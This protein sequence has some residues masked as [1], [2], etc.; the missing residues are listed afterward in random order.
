MKGTTR[1]WS[2]ILAISFVLIGAINW[3]VIGLGYSNV[4]TRLVS[5]NSA[6]IVYIIIGLSGLYFIFN[7]DTFLPFLG[8]M[9][10]PGYA[11]KVSTPEN[12]NLKV[13]VRAHK[14]AIKIVY[15]GANPDEPGDHIIKNPIKAYKDSDN[16]GV[17]DVGND[18]TATLYFIC[19]QQYKVGRHVLSKHIHYRSVF[20]NGMMSPVETVY[21]D[22][23]N[24]TL[25]R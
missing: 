23:E 18:G 1:V 14:D 19:P 8:H 3:L 24:K 13:K 10:F 5:Q 2:H 17:V 16:V 11:L 20:D 6:R 15:W 4:V 12:A 21:I 22:C 7:R 25:I 9:A